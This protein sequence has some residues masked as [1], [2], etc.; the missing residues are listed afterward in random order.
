MIS[1]MLAVALSAKINLD[2]TIVDRFDMV[3]VN[4]FYNEWG[5]EVWSQVVF[6]DWHDLHKTFHVQHWIMMRDA[7]EIT[8]EGKKKHEE[9]VRE[10]ESKYKDVNTR[11][12]LRSVSDY[13]GDFI[14]GKL[15]PKKD[16]KNNIYVIQYTDESKIPRRI[17]AK[18]FR[19]T[20]TQED[21]EREDKRNYPEASRRKLKQPKDIITEDYSYFESIIKTLLSTH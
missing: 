5:F 2:N 4:H 12:A 16:W 3:E 15:Y 11:M 19:E 6:W 8:E 21:P 14:G 20:H 9:L 18:Q 1:V 13:K 17:E 7:Y 10:A